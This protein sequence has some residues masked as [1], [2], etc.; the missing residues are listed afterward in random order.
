MSPQAAASTSSTISGLNLGPTTESALVAMIDHGMGLNLILCCLPLT[1]SAIR[2]WARTAMREVPVGPIKRNTRHP[3]AWRPDEYRLLTEGWLAN[4]SA[5]DIAQSI[6]R[7]RDSVY[8]KRRYLGLPARDRKAL[9][10]VAKAKSEN[11]PRLPINADRVLTAS[12]ARAMPTKERRGKRW[13]VD[14]S[15]LV[16]SMKA[17]RDELVWTSEMYDEV[18]LRH[19]ALQHPLQN[20]HDWGVTLRTIQSAIFWQELPDRDRSKL[21]PGFNQRVGADNLSAS[22]YVKRKCAN[23]ENWSFWSKE[24]GGARLSRRYKSSKAYADALASA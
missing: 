14:N 1:E 4:S 17:N 6:G 5:L 7:S 15:D 12:Q 24:K 9:A 20:A 2:D 18:A 23:L 3:R 8:A 22:G 21:V 19:A 13:R 16:I 10:L 11:A